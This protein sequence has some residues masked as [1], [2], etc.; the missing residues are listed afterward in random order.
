MGKTVVIVE[1]DMNVIM[2]HYEKIFVMDYGVNIAEGPAE[3]IQNNEQVAPLCA[4]LHEVAFPMAES[5]AFING[6][7]ALVDGTAA[8][9]RLAATL[10]VTPSPARL[11]A[12][13]IAMQLL[14][15]HRPAV[16]EAVDRLMADPVLRSHQPKPAGDLFR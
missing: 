7:P 11:S 8:W 4:E 3:E 5:L 12:R 2:N 14:A 9:D 15:T 6:L 16:D 13:Q 10:E 1:H